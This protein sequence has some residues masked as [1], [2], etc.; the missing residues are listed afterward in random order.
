MD[1]ASDP[2]ASLAVNKQGRNRTRPRWKNHRVEC[3]M[4]KVKRLRD[5][6]HPKQGFL[7]FF[8]FFFIY[9]SNANQYSKTEE[10]CLWTVQ[11][12]TVQM[13]YY[14]R[15][16]GLRSRNSSSASSPSSSS[17]KKNRLR[18]RLIDFYKTK[19]KL[20]YLQDVHYILCFFIF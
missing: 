6:N 18:T 8:Y 14:R 10:H 11:Y 1:P 16:V 13:L 15:P 5:S 17:P 7:Y 20:F 4:K 12:C 2:R 3:P 9:C 19:K